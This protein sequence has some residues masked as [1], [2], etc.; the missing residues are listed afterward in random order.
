MKRFLNLLPF[1]LLSGFCSAQLINDGGVITIKPGATL[2]VESDVTNNTVGANTGTINV[3]GTLEVQGNL[4]NNAT[5][6]TISGSLVKFS[7]DTNSDFLSNGA[8]IE[9]LQVDKDHATNGTVTL[10]DDLTVKTNLDFEPSTNGN[11]IVI[12]ANDLILSEQTTTV[13]DPTG[14]DYIVADGT[15]MVQKNTDADSSFDFPIGDA[16]DYS[17]VNVNYTSGNSTYTSANV[18]ASVAAVKHPNT[19]ADADDHIERYWNVDQSGIGSYEATLTGTYVAG[20]VIGGMASDI[21]GASQADGSAGMSAADWD[22]AGSANAANQVSAMVSTASTD[23]TGF[24]FFGKANLKVYLQGAYNS[25]TGM[26]STTLSGLAAF[27]TTTPYTVAPFNA[28]SESLPGAVIPANT[29]DWI[30]VEAREA[31]NPSTVL[32]Q[33]SA[34]LKN[35]G[36]IVDLDGGDLFIKDADPS[37]IIAI[38]HMNHLSIRTSTGID[39]MSNSLYDFST[40]LGQVY[41]DPINL[42][43]D[44]MIQVGSDFNMLCGD[45]SNDDV[46]NF[47]DLLNTNAASTPSSTNVYN[48]HD[49][50]FDGILNFTDLLNTNGFATPSKTAHF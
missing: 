1:L 44:A 10:Q 32:A 18:K 24:N 48:K 21:L 41:T 19:P 3:E 50:S 16:D 26:M 23:F 46:I 22:F 45:T 17:P 27:P 9:N 14:N 36:T 47:T 34:I 15:G 31:G 4:T 13:T 49:V 29:T 28:P 30:L 42:V 11:K 40:G 20:D 8:V 25:G 7:G 38:K 2:Y 39:L 33:K 6:S 37:S 12:G 43:N 35:D 5:M